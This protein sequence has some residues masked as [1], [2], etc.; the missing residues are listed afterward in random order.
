M[1][2]KR[3]TLSISFPFTFLL[4][5]SAIGS[6]VVS[7]LGWASDAEV[8]IENMRNAFYNCQIKNLQTIDIGQ[9]KEQKA[10]L[11]LTNLCL[12]EYS[13]LNKILA[14]QNLTTSNEQRMFTIDQ[15]SDYAKI[16]A[17]LPMI[18]LKRYAL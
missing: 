16:D 9:L 12:E 17:S 5:I 15:N 4:L 18:K 10:A 13:A 3:R 1:S 7:P 11:T 6:L 8:I 14:R 2:A